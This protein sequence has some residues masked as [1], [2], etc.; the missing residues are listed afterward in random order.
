MPAVEIK[1]ETSF[2]L[3]IAL[4]QVCPLHFGN[5]IAC[6]E[7]LKTYCGS[8]WFTVEWKRDLETKK[9]RYSAAKSAKAIALVSLATV[10]CVAVAGPLAVGAAAA[11]GSASAAALLA[12]SPALIAAGSAE[13]L[14]VSSVLGRL[15]QPTFSPS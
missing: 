12:S 1:N 5:A 13:A 8:V 14:A 11:A 2:P 9:S 6:G 3:N 7:S 10:G 15:F 4:S